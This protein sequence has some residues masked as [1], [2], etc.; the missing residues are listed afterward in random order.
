METLT[1]STASAIA[2]KLIETIMFFSMFKGGEN[3]IKMDAHND[4]ITRLKFISKISKGEKLNVKNGTPF[5]QSNDVL[6]RLS[7]T[8]FHKD[9][10]NNTLNFIRNTIERSFEIISLYKTSDKKSDKSMCDNICKDLNAAIRGINNLKDTYSSDTMFCCEIDTILQ[11]IQSRLT[12]LNY[13]EIAKLVDID[14]GGAED[15][16]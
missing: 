1:L 12:E 13:E 16:K 3:D 15:E 5:V 14:G 7:R 8:F 2:Y 11:K 9:N 6:T 10:R 4:I